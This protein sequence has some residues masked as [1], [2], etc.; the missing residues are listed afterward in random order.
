MPQ[1]KIVFPEPVQIRD[2]D[3]G[4]ALTGPEGL[5][6]FASFLRK[7]FTNPLWNESWKQGMAQRSI[8]QAV[9][10]AVAGKASTLLIAEE[11]WE[12]LVTAAKTPR[13]AVLVAGMGMQIIPGF[14]YLPSI[15]GQLVPMQL[16]IINA[17]A[18]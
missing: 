1:R 8:A 10:E 14:G 6:D 3:S 18:V 12:F 11:D 7:L 15:A 17:E 13:T 16:A 9:K 5:L 4:Q 2:P